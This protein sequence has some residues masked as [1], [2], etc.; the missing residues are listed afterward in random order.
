MTPASGGSRRVPDIRYGE[1]PGYRPLELDL[2]LPEPGEPAPVIVHVHGGG[3]RREPRRH[4]PPWTC[5]M[6]GA[7]SS[8]PGRYRSSSRGR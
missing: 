3:W 5:T 6:T 7:G 4:P 2:Y 1:V 8:V